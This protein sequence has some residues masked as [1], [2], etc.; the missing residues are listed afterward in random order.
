MVT[1]CIARPL[2]NTLLLLIAVMPLTGPRL[3]HVWE[4]YYPHIAIGLGAFVA[5]YYLMSVPSGAD[6][7]RHTAHEYFS[8][9]VLIGSLFVVAGGI[10]I[11]VKGEATPA[12]NVAFRSG[13]TTVIGGLGYWGEQGRGKVAPYNPDGWFETA[14]GEALNVNL[15][16]NVAIGGE[17]VYVLI[18]F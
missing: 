12:V 5:A 4:R 1:T 3:K 10:H 18:P 14:A 9:I 15:S 2:T 13:S 17:L 7:V 6:I 16:G 8:F 11:S